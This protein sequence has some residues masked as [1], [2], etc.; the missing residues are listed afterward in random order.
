VKWAFLKRNAKINGS[1]AIGGIFETCVKFIILFQEEIKIID[2]GV[3]KLKIKYYN[4]NAE[5]SSHPD[6]FPEF[7]YNIFFLFD[8]SSFLPSTTYSLA[9]RFRC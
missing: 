8:L 5:T 7:H 4:V 9:D 3:S 2:P 6:K 1:V